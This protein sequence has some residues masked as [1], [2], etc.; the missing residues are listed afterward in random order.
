MPRDMQCICGHSIHVA[1][2]GETRPAFA[3]LRGATFFKEGWPNSMR[4][5]T[6]IALTALLVVTVFDVLVTVFV[7]FCK[8][9][10]KINS[11]RVCC[12]PKQVPRWPCISRARFYWARPWGLVGPRRAA[13]I[14]AMKGYSK[15]A[16]FASLYVPERNIQW[17]LYETPFFIIFLSEVVSVVLWSG[18]WAPLD[19]VNRKTYRLLGNEVGCFFF[20]SAL[21][22]RKIFI[23]S[24]DHWQTM[25]R[26][27]SL[28]S[29]P[30]TLGKTLS[31]WS[32]ALTRSAAF[33]CTRTGCTT[34]GWYRDVP[35]SLLRA[36]IFSSCL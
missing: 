9:H 26:R 31:S 34:S 35:P 3:A 25:R 24:W 1:V 8:T 18:H 14:T 23:A 29:L 30:T 4:E 20:T 11:V 27:Y 36:A 10:S 19:R 6:V 7:I 28:K 5:Y 21:C 16:R 15:I 2:N 33:D 17:Y 12:F 13:S 32:T 22:I